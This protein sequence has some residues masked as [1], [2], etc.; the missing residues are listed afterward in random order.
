LRVELPENLSQM[1]PAL[2]RKVG[3]DRETSLPLGILPLRGYVR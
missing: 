1:N 3:D 2:P